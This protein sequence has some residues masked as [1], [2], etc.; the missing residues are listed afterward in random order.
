M[1]KTVLFLTAVFAFLWASGQNNLSA[2][3]QNVLDLLEEEKLAMEVYNALNEKW[4]HH[5]FYNISAAEERHLEMMT[6]LAQHYQ[7]KVP[8]S[9]I[10]RERGVFQNAALQELYKQLLREGDQSLAAA[11][12]AGARIEETDIRD[13]KQAISATGDAEAIRVYTSLLRASENHL[14][15]FQ[16]NLDRLGETYTP[17]ALAA[18]D[19]Q[20]IIDGKNT[21][22]GACCKNI[23][24]Q[25]PGDCKA[26]AGK[27]QGK[28]RRNAG[29]CNAQ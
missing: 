5:S 8:A 19:Y 27:G 10:R 3:Q 20:A 4:G 15:A 26:G 6:Q 29:C 25:S 9:V 13:L 28:G 11:L 16:R 21:C 24:G 23:S 12:K 1:K 18:T 2:G 17:T 22:Q 7:L 14:R